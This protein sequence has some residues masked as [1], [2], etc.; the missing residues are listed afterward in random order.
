MKREAM[1]LSLMEHRG[2]IGALALGQHDNQPFIVLARLAAVLSEVLPRAEGRSPVARV[3]SP[4]ATRAGRLGVCVCG[5]GGGGHA[6]WPRA[7][8]H[9]PH[10]A[11]PARRITRRCAAALS[12]RRPP[13]SPTPP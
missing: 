6:T 13:S 9:Q 5:E 4:A 3:V 11:S 2:I 12:V 1:L 7:E 8:G 10:S